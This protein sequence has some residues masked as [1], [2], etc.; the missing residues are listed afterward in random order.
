MASKVG[1]AGP[2]SNVLNLMNDAVSSS[3]PLSRVSRDTRLVG[4]IRETSVKVM[5]KC[6]NSNSSNVS[7]FLWQT[8][9]NCWSVN[10]EAVFSD[11]ADFS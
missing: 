9:E 1:S 3:C 4:D 8:V 10:C 6:F 11:S 2:A 7:E 5:F